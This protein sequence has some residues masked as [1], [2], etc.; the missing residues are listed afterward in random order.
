[1]GCAVLNVSSSCKWQ[2]NL[3]LKII[4]V[5]LLNQYDFFKTIF[6]KAP[7]Q[8]SRYK[9][10]AYLFEDHSG[11]GA[12]VSAAT[13]GLR[14]FLQSPEEGQPGA[15]SHFLRRIGRRVLP[16][17]EFRSWPRRRHLSSCPALPHPLTSINAGAS[18]IRLPSYS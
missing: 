15:G 10:I 5:L 13:T 6:S 16:R 17:Q 1:M 8:E 7:L 18:Y 11:L 2:K 12:Y 9:N 3:I 14:G 4:I